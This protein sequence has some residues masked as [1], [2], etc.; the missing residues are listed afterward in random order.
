[1]NFVQKKRKFNNIEINV[2]STYRVLVF[3]LLIKT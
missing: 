1:M 3:A 2:K